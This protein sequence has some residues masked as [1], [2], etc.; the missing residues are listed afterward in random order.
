MQLDNETIEKNSRFKFYELAWIYIPV[1]LLCIGIDRLIS[2]FETINHPYLKTL[3]AL[4]GFLILYE[5]VFRSFVLKVSGHLTKEKFSQYVVR[6]YAGVFS[7]LYF[8]NFFTDVNVYYSVTS[9]ILIVSTSVL[10]LLN[11]N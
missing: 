4:V 7:L 1:L 8:L 5:V 3:F 10:L 9:A 11:S 6:L 2:S